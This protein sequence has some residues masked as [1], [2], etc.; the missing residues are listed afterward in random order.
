MHPLI[1]ALLKLRELRGIMPRR[2][3]PYYPLWMRMEAEQRLVVA[4][5]D[6]EAARECGDER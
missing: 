6:V 1:A 3:S 2:W 4:E 5:L